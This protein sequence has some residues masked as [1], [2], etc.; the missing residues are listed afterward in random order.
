MEVLI[1]SSEIFE[2]NVKPERSKL[3]F[4][5]LGDSLRK[6]TCVLSSE[7]KCSSKVVITPFLVG[8][9]VA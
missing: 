1:D 3:G 5:G 9:V 4:N 6:S 2:D 7:V 8:S